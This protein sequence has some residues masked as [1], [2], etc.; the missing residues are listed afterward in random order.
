MSFEETLQELFEERADDLTPEHRRMLW[1]L[2]RRAE[3]A[4]RA[5]RAGDFDRGRT[6]GLQELA[7]LFSKVLSGR[8]LQDVFF[9]EGRV[10]TYQPWATDAL[11]QVMDAGDLEEA[12][13]IASELGKLDTGA[14]MSRVGQAQ[15]PPELEDLRWHGSSM[16][17]R[18]A[19]TE[20][21]LL[22]RL[23]DRDGDKEMR[24]A[25]EEL[26]RR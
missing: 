17:N 14:L 26:N 22:E 21:E 16:N 6:A 19:M 15:H 23:W 24:K 20:A 5:S 9:L 12:E 13:R 11:Q 10:M 2:W 4:G 1:T 8:K 18:T 25:N 3:E 7:T